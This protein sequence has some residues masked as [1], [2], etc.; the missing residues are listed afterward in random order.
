MRVA[1]L[2]VISLSLGGCF[3]NPM[4]D[5]QA[6]AAVDRTRNPTSA[7]SLFTWN[8]GNTPERGRISEWAAEFHRGQLHRVETP[9]HRLVADCDK[10][11]GTVLDVKT[12]EQFTND[13]VAK[14]AC[15][16][17]ANVSIVTMRFLGRELGRFG[18][19]DRVEITDNDGGL[20]TYD[21]DRIGAIVGQTIKD[22][23]G[24]TRQI[25]ECRAGHPCNHRSTETAPATCAI[26]GPARPCRAR[27]TARPDHRR[28]AACCGSGGGCPPHP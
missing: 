2:L 27:C 20:R 7:Y 12:G 28:S 19:V 6:Q 1:L 16:V 23:Q 8:E 21:I 15:G 4:I 14:A 10:G 11:T 22:W 17:D 3:Q 26:P 18:F 13:R 5:E 24:N 9:L 25:D